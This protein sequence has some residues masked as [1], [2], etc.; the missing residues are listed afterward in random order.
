VY[1]TADQRARLLDFCVQYQFDRLALGAYFEDPRSDSLRLR[2]ADGLARFLRDAARRGIAVGA[3]RGARDMA[4]GRNR[5]RALRELD[6]V[7]AFDADQ[8]DSAGFV[9]IHYDVEPYLTDAWRAGG[10]ERRR[11]Q[12]DYLDFLHAARRH[13]RSRAP[14]VRLVV[15][16]PYWYDKADLAL[17]YGGRRQLFSE[18]VLDAADAVVLMSYNRDPARVAEQVAGEAAYASRLGKGV[19][20]GMEVGFVRGA[21]HFISFQWVPTWRF[22]RARCT[23]EDDARQR[24]GLQG[25]YVH[26]YRALYQKLTGEPPW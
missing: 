1:A 14:D 22:W 11:T 12:A 24:P 25:V 7:L 8:P 26:H 13:L 2:H 3:L 23:I 10:D 15:D 6:A 17:D 18:H 9:E 19:Y 16:T 20:A 4:T 21:E 5:P